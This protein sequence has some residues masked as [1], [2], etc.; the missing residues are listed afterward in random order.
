MIDI[1]EIRIG[2]IVDYTIN[3]IGGGVTI[4]RGRITSLT[5]NRAI[6]NGKSTKYC[7]LNPINIDEDLL[8][9]LRFTKCFHDILN[10][11]YYKLILNGFC[12]DINKYSNTLGRDYGVHIDNLCCDSVLSGDIQYLHQIQNYIYDSTH[13]E[14]DVSMLIKK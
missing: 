6:V 13:Q 3:N 11:Y 4:Q 5:E 12:I 2:S 10:E 8:L 7:N 1:K 14:L 9:K